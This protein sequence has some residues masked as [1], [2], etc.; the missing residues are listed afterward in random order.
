MR[1]E[2]VTG[3]IDGDTLSI[4]AAWSP[5][6]LT[7]KVRIRG[8]D[9]PEKGYLAK[10]KRERE[11]SISAVALTRS[12]VTNSGGQIWLRN[13]KHDK[14]GGRIV[15]DVYTRD[16]R[17]VGDALLNAGLA[18]RYNGSGPKPSWCY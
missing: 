14:Y 4:A 11:L 2:T 17:S 1:S 6:R 18:K 5:Y 15:A 13:V 16:G 7:W 12:L 8:V 3:V 9:T 10:C